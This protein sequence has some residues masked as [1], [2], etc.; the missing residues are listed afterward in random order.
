MEYLRIFSLSRLITKLL[1]LSGWKLYN[2]CSV[3]LIR[4]KL[5]PEHAARELVCADVTPLTPLTTQPQT[6]G[7]CAAMSWCHFNQYQC[8][9]RLIRKLIRWYFPIE[10]RKAPIKLFCFS[11][12]GFR[13]DEGRAN[14][15]E[16]AGWMG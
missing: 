13:K 7:D 16:G 5:V 6:P 3:L 2:N 8:S 10:R 12:E 14:C 15:T 9:Q 11:Q 1:P 4:H